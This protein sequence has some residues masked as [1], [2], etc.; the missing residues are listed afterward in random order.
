[1]LLTIVFIPF[2][3]SFFFGRIY[4]WF[5]WLYFK[6]LSA[7]VDYLEK[8]FKARD[9][10]LATATQVVVYL[11]CLP[12]IFIMHVC[13]AFVSFI[14]FFEWAVLMF[15]A[16]VMTL[17]AVRWQPVVSDATFDA[18]PAPAAA[19]PAP[20]A[21]EPA[22]E[23]TEPAPEVAEPAPEAAEPAPEAVEPAPEAAE[24]EAA[25]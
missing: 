3:V 7:P 5:T 12:I 8:W 11:I 21:A 9:N 19:E 24:T 16:F 14:F 22:P 6:A 1:M 2:R 17:G 25:E 10:G 23:A 4:Y 20:E 18:E 13:L 15:L